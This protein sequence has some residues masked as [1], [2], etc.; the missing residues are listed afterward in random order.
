[1]LRHIFIYLIFITILISGTVSYGLSKPLDYETLSKFFFALYL[2]S[3]IWFFTDAVPRL[4]KMFTTEKG[5]NMAMLVSN[6][7]MVTIIIWM[8]RPDLLQNP[9]ISQV[10]AMVTVGIALMLTGIM[11]VAFRWYVK[12]KGEN[13]PNKFRSG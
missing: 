12:R 3:L 7:V 11:R 4:V 8:V 2:V 13:P 5:R 9:D 10:L 6:A 1:M